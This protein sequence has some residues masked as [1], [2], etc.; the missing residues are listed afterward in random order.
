[1]AKVKATRGVCIGPE[2]HLAVGETAD[3]DT[4]TAQFLVSINAV[5]LVKDEPAAV[6]EA[7]AADPPADPQA[8]DET[9]HKGK[10]GK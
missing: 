4:A 2:K 8:T 9:P 3:V 10:R 7:P 5:E 1:M 6:D